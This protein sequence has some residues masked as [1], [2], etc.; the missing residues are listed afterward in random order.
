MFLAAFFTIATN[1][2]SVYEH[3]CKSGK[4]ASFSLISAPTCSMEKEADPCCANKSAHHVKITKS[5]CEK[6]SIFKK[7]S[8]DGF[9]VKAFSFK[10]SDLVH[11]INSH[12]SI[13]IHLPFLQNFFTGLSPPYPDYEIAQHL[14]PTQ[15]GLQV[16]IC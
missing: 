15:P 14:Q 2:V 4:M 5:C 13:E 7:F 16:F 11:F 10:F 8:F 12:L 3:F 1:G 9:I 6:K